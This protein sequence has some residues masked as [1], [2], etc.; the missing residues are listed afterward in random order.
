MFRDQE[1]FYVVFNSENQPGWFGENSPS[2]FVLRDDLDIPENKYEVKLVN[3]TMPRTVIPY[4]QILVCLEGLQHSYAY[5]RNRVAL[6]AVVPCQ[7]GSGVW[8]HDGPD[9]YRPMERRLCGPRALEVHITDENHKPVQFE[10][11]NPV[12]IT[13]HFRRMRNG[14]RH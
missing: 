4:S 14:E 8:N 9:I 7:K 10:G 6:L 11:D 3:I 5:Q 13:L 1:E 12:N 2:H